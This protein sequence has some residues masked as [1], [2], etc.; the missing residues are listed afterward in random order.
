MLSNLDNASVREATNLSALFLARAMSDQVGFTFV[1]HQGA[2]QSVSFA[3]MFQRALAL[4][5]HLQTSDVSKGDRVLFQL[6][7]CEEVITSFW[8]C[9]IAQL[10]PVVLN[11]APS[12]RA[13]NHQLEKV[14]AVI[15]HLSV[16]TVLCSPSLQGDISRAVHGTSAARILVADCVSLPSHGTAPPPALPECSADD[17]A[18]IF[19]TSGSTGVPKAVP[20]THSAMMAMA[21]GTIA[22]NGFTAEHTTLNWM[23]M[24]HAGALVFLGVMPMMLGARQIHAPIE[25]VLKSPLRWL[26]L[27]DEKRAAISW[28]PNFVFSLMLA[29]A[30]QIEAGSWDLS[31]MR[32]MVN[33]GEAVV[34]ST[35]RAF[36]RLMESK[37]LPSGALKPAFGMVET[38]SGITWS[39]GFTLATTKDTDSFVNL[40]GVIPGGEIKVVDDVDQPLAEGVEGRLMIKGPSVFTG[41]LNTPE[42]NADIFRDGWFETG[43]LAVIQQNELFVT[44]RSKEVLI[45]NG[46]NYYCHDIE[47]V[48]AELD[49]VVAESVAAVGVPALKGGTERPLI[50]YATD[51][52]LNAA[53]REL[54]EKQLSTHIVNSCGVAPGGYILL[55]AEA[56]P[57]TAIGKIQRAVLKE[58]FVNGEYNSLLRGLLLREQEQGQ[59]SREDTPADALVDMRSLADNIKGIWCRVLGV[60]DLHVDDMFFEVGGSSLAAIQIQSELEALIGRTISMAELFDTPTVRTMAAYFGGAL[61]P[62]AGP[63]VNAR[64]AKGWGSD[65]AVIGIGCRFPG[66]NGPAQFWDVLENC[67][68]T[69]TRFAAED[70]IGV[71]VAESIAHHPD[72]VNAA[73]I[74][75]DIEGCDLDFWKFSEREASIIDPQ[76]RVFLETAWEAFEDAGYEPGAHLGRVAVYASAATNTYQHNNLYA[77]SGWVKQHGGALLTVD[78]YDGFNVMTSN[79]KDYLPTR[80]SF[81]LDLVG[82]S[83]A[84]QTA[85]S[86]TLVAVHEAVKSLRL[87]ESE[88]A[89]AGGCA[90]ML[91][92]HAGHLY[93]EGMI[94]SPDGHCRAYD[95]DA[96]G[97]IFGSGSGAVIL[98]R[99]EDAVADGD[100]VYAVIKGSGV[101]N[102]G[103]QKMGY[104]AP[105]MAGETRAIR[106]ALSDAGINPESVGYVEGHGTGTPIGDPI[107]VQALAN[108][109][110]QPAE[111]ASKCALGSVKTNIGHMGIASGIAGFI[112]TALALHHKKRPGTVHFKRAN[113]AIDFE[114]TPFYVSAK[115]EAWRS[116]TPR[117]A[118][119]NSLGI[120][121]TNVHVILEE[122]PSQSDNLL[123]ESPA[124]LPNILPL[125]A[126]TPEALQQFSNSMYDFLKRHPD[127]NLHDVAYTFQQGRRAFS[128]RHALVF[129]DREELLST[130]GQLEVT[131]ATKSAERVVFLFTGQGSQ[132]L[133]MAK[134][135][136]ATQPV[137]K[138]AFLQ[139]AKLFSGKRDIA[140]ETL[141]MTPDLVSDAEAVLNSTEYTQPVLFAL[142][143]ALTSLYRA[144]GIEPSAVVGHSVGEVAAVV[145]AGGLTVEDG[146]KLVET[147]SRLMQAVSRRGAMAAVTAQPLDL[148]SLLFARG[149]SVELAAVN[150]A[151]EFTI[152][153]SVDAIDAAI[154]LFSEYGLR[155]TRL[156]VSHAFHS[157]DFLEIQDKFREEIKAL[158][159]NPVRLSMFNNVDGSDLREVV[160]DADYWV[161]QVCS[162]VLF[163][164]AARHALQAGHRLFVEMGPQPV[165]CGFGR[166][167]D[168]T[169]EA[170]WLPSL[171]KGQSDRMQFYRSLGSLFDSGQAIKWDGLV[172]LG[173][174][175]ISALPTYPWQRTRCWIEPDGAATAARPVSRGLLEMPI[176][177][178]GGQRLYAQHYSPVIMK[179]LNEHRVFGRVVPPAAL[180]VAQSLSVAADYAEQPS[181]CLE[182]L[183]FMAPMVL[184]ESDHRE[185]HLVLQPHNRG[186]SIE[187]YSQPVL[188]ETKMPD[189]VHH[190]TAELLSAAPDITGPLKIE[191]LKKR[192]HRARHP[193]EITAYMAE[194][195]IQLGASFRRLDTLWTGRGEALAKLTPSAEGENTEGSA[196]TAGL[197]D[198]HWQT[199]L[200]ALDDLPDST[201]VPAKIEQ[202]VL[203][204]VNNEMPQW[205]YARIRSTD[206]TQITM[207]VALLNAVGERLL[208]TRGLTLQR[209]SPELFSPMGQHAMLVRWHAESVRGAE[210][211]VSP[212]KALR[213]LSSSPLNAAQPMVFS[214]DAVSHIEWVVE[215]DL[216]VAGSVLGHVGQHIVL[217]GAAQIA[218]LT[219]SVNQTLLSMFEHHDDLTTFVIIMSRDVTSLPSDDACIAAEAFAIRAQIKSLAKEYPGVVLS[220]VDIADDSVITPTMFDPIMERS[221]AFTLTDGVLS[222]YSLDVVFD[223]AS[224]AGGQPQ[225]SSD[226]VQIISGGLGG[227][228]LET[229]RWMVGCGARKLVL[230]GRSAPDADSALVINQLRQLGATI[231]VMQ[232][233][234]SCLEDVDRVAAQAGQYGELEVIVHAAG[235][236][237][238]GAATNLTEAA[239]AMTFDAKVHGAFN[240]ID[241]TRRAPAKLTVFFSS[242]A[243]WFGSEGQSN[244]AAAN[245]ALEGLASVIDGPAARVLSVAWG[246]WQSTGMT[247]R[248]K[249]EQLAYIE[250]RGY[251]FL[252]AEEAFCQLG[253]VMAGLLS[254]TTP[255]GPV[256]SEAQDGLRSFTSLAILKGDGDSLSNLSQTSLDSG[257][258]LAVS[259]ISSSGDAA[260]ADRLRTDQREAVEAH[261]Q[262]WL[263]QQVVELTALRSIDE[264][265][266]DAGFIDLG[267]D[268]LA[269][270]ELRKRLEKETGLPLKST[271]I[272][273]YP[274]VRTMI[275]AL[276][277]L[278]G[279]ADETKNL[280][281]QAQNGESLMEQL[282]REIG[283]GDNG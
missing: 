50:F 47:R 146:A 108:A 199:G 202:L 121:G 273:D 60:A 217:S 147:R 15:D 227:V 189:V 163:K 210:I 278:A 43:D 158:S 207:D 175:R 75:E 258:S 279:G 164:E 167:T 150:S 63:S 10:V 204:T 127:V 144:A 128:A 235:A 269:G 141:V 122:A 100:A 216:L 123:T 221:D 82:P 212:D 59:R 66:A 230:F 7:S 256:L 46:N 260:L 88:M 209:V 33:A 131:H 237:S 36:I 86:S 245:A 192:C 40:G 78:S 240:L 79:D 233:D 219:Q 101:A 72:Q 218:E 179:S 8:A 282:A 14:R 231:E 142:Q 51:V 54:L 31:S 194:R 76:Q 48:A 178:P 115:T 62:D 23:S 213:V 111:A 259:E 222:R 272:L 244:Y 151:T 280:G 232:A 208:D 2:T 83:L 35:A 265:D 64:T 215:S 143:V 226:S 130:L 195:G 155:A 243:A 119:V 274:S 140:I 198:S 3:A 173:G 168:S 99:L 242:T 160:H 56:F 104:A 129:R 172:G 266:F 157:S 229:A 182:Q 68:E 162:P 5:Q 271:L 30:D 71:G 193:S 255:V 95:A 92:Q 180:Y 38:C 27:I 45:I 93:M 41:Y 251:G 225:F 214:D 124:E 152:S 262:E 17:V 137:F 34:S 181:V 220:T 234:V 201:M 77:N 53:D 250:Q 177:L 136:L 126:V 145:A 37:G 102:D 125:S 6:L 281:E 39:K 110:N 261:L 107:E 55:A 12:Y 84:V 69:I 139:V 42:L 49:G 238:D 283:M 21:D 252:S 228:G 248:L 264:V 116:S 22:M 254:Q 97:T 159:F 113:P 270:L 58:G 28:A 211:A 156:P 166:N 249:Q 132:Y 275:D 205:A 94:N 224:E 44:G 29:K 106:E 183:H 253:P 25:Y 67:Q 276:L 133:A 236:V 57:R 96:Q 74:L 105:S 120:G 176:N 161:Q 186:A 80:V 149:A 223:E 118:G 188:S 267:V 241:A 81:K 61:E 170:T 89:V 73:P 263:A 191:D 153:G 65:I 52:D 90:L 117:R 246:P 98:K 174:R 26:D 24:D 16:S 4:S 206:T 165:L 134:E 277:T 257:G 190:I 239:F 18:V 171:R 19:L 196:L 91:P 184:A 20:Q 197:I 187:L 203:H 103:A 32:F 185:V 268:S 169:D 85:C 200:A 13:E 148:T 112:K 247:S 9:I 11:P 154:T 109:F 138:E 135:L 87:G 70:A 1:D 114:R